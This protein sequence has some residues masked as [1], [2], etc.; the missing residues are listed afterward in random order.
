MTDDTAARPGMAS[1]PM[2]ASSEA[3]TPKVPGL[4][5]ALGLVVAAQFV[6]QLD[7][8]IVN[9]A[10]PTI[11]HEL[12]FV[13]AELQW[14]VTGYALT[15]GSLLLLGGRV[16]D[17]VGHRRV[18]L[19][20][21]AV[22]G[23]T[24]LVAGF[25]P[26]PIVLIVSRFCQGASGAFVAPQALAV[27]TELFAEGPPRTKALGVFAGVTAAGA[28]AG[29][30]LGGICTEF[31]SWR[32]VFLVNPPIIV[33]LVI[34]IR[35]VIPAHA[36]RATA[37]LDI[38]GPV[39]ATASIA[40]LILGLSQG[41]QY[42]FAN[43][44]ALV[45]LTLAVVLGG[46]F[47]VTQR[48]GKAPMIPAQLLADPARRAA[49]SAMLLFGAVV[50]GYVY[51]TSL[52]NQDV[53]G[54]SPLEAGLAFI[55]ATGM[56]MLIS[57]QLTR[58]VLARFGVRR[59][60][61]TGL[62]ITGLGQVWLST[63][64]GAGSYQLNVRGGILLTAFGMGLVFPTISVAVT[65]GVG[66]GERGLAG[67]LYVTAQQV[68]LAVGLAALATIA[69]AETNAHHRSLAIGYQTAFRVS[70]GLSVVAV[71]IV[72]VQMRTRAAQVET[73]DSLT[74]W[75]PRSVGRRSGCRPSRRLAQKGTAR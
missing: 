28:S 14:I 36:H 58:R 54:F 59:I 43:A 56:V 66:P 18:L 32:A 13:P 29:V 23:V 71:L 21:L 17:R 53:L 7:S 3:G 57:T 33:V 34:A 20:G 30:V 48:R 37:R 1:A 52:Y 26:V 42:G 24:S 25:A 12:H 10:L 49:L 31:I 61:L 64:S 4:G 22:F 41:Q 50:V 15:F 73:Q 40:L 5:W 65:S 39:L 38:A 68:G 2:P 47:I 45:A 70:I 27:I 11:K 8:S 16:G 9:I 75:R 44:F 19:I 63:I 6:L 35:R 62:T 69:A 74:V 46:T 72:A 67:G 55:P 51:F 60:L